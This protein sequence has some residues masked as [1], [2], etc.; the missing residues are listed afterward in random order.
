MSCFVPKHYQT[1]DLTAAGMKVT[2]SYVFYLSKVLSQ[3]KYWIHAS[4]NSEENGILFLNKEKLDACWPLI[5]FKVKL[6]F[7]H[8]L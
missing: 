4:Q 8:I 7:A 2:G 3:G 5:V 6:L 1:G